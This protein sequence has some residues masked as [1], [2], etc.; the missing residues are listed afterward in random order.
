MGVRPRTRCA[1]WL[2]SSTKHEQQMPGQVSWML[3][4]QVQDGREHDF[5]ALMR[6]MVDATHA[7]EPGALNCEWSTT[8]DGKQC[9]LYERYADDTAAMMH[10]GTFGERFAGR[11][12]EILKP[13][14]FVVYGSSSTEV[15]GALAAVN[16][17]YMEPA[18]GFSC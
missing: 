3:D 15:R 18:A 1:R 14:R 9:H 5:R 7:S 12:L 8:P 10:I 4:L 16:P 6:E 17:V 13:T 11:F 2:I